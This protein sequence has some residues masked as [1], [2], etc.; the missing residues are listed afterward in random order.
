MKTE[1]GEQRRRQPELGIWKSYFGRAAV[2]SAVEQEIG[3]TECKS[4][5][6]NFRYLRGLSFECLGGVRYGSV[7]TKGG[8]SYGFPLF[9]VKR[10]GGMNNWLK[11]IL[12][13]LIFSSGMKIFLLLAIRMGQNKY[14][15]STQEPN[16]LEY[17]FLLYQKLESTDSRNNAVII[18]G[19]LYWKLLQMKSL[20]TGF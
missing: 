1:W 14:L 11:W 10:W 13:I 19:Y 6:R 5:T 4:Q 17:T 12:Q 18:I 2:P 8:E 7:M 3:R 16:F 15:W 9:C 20:K